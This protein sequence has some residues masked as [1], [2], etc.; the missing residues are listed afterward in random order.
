MRHKKSMGE[1]VRDAMDHYWSV[2]YSKTDQGLDATERGWKRS[3][4]RDMARLMEKFGD[5]WESEFKASR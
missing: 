3:H 2:V 1:I 4:Q 5:R